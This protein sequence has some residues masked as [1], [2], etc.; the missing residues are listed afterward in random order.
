VTL[1]SSLQSLSCGWGVNQ[2]LERVTL[3][4]SLQSLSFGSG[5]RQSLDRVTLPSSLQK[6]E[7]CRLTDLAPSELYVSLNETPMT[8]TN[9]LQSPAA[10]SSK[11]CCLRWIFFEY[12]AAVFAE[13]SHINTFALLRQFELQFQGERNTVTCL[14]SN[15][16]S[17]RENCV[18]CVRYHLFPPMTFLQIPLAGR[19]AN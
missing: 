3:P 7:T 6:L 11:N 10:I 4:S 16:M 18:K 17:G 8:D 19:K 15:A 2:S 1:P 14:G 13:P 5:L 12:I 9:V